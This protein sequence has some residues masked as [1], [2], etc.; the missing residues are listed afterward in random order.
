[1][2]K[3]AER[4]H[5]DATKKRKA[6]DY[7]TRVVYLR[8]GEQPTQRMIGMRASTPQQC[9]CMGC[10]HRRYHNGPTIAERRVADALALG[11]DDVQARDEREYDSWD[12]DDEPH[13]CAGDECT[14]C[15]RVISGDGWAY[16]GE[17]GTDTTDDVGYSFDS[18]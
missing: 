15:V 18:E 11:L 8:P 17:H 9:S 16:H 4:R 6:K 13:W 2:S 5:H 14:G 1:M 12:W 10:G 7:L 3:R